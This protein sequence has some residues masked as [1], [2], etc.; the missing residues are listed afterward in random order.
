MARVAHLLAGPRRLLRRAPRALVLLAFG[1]E[2]PVALEPHDLG[3]ALAQRCLRAGELGSCGRELALAR[4][5]CEL[6]GHGRRA[7]DA[8][9]GR[10]LRV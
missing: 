9:C 6:R 7:R 2:A 10:E 5:E 1:E 8:L 3:L 4:G